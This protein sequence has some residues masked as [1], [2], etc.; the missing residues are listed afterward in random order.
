MIDK[1]K[2]LVSENKWYAIAAA[3]V[4]VAVVLLAS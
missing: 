2:T 4:V 1:I 3:A